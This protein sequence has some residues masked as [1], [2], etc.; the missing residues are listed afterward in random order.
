LPYLLFDVETELTP[1]PLDLHRHVPGMTVAAT[2]T[3]DG[4]LRLW[5]EQAGEGKAT[6][7]TL[8]RETAQRLVRYLHDQAAEG[9]TIVTW[10]GA[11]FDFR[12]LARASGMAQACIELAWQ[13]VDMMFWFHCVQG[14][15]VGLSRAAA[16]VG[17]SKTVGMSGAD[18]PRLWAEGQYERVKE[19][20]SQDVRAA[21][22]VYEATV[23]N[24]GLQWVNTRGQ[25]SRAS[26]PL[27]PV[28][29]AFQLPLPDTSWMRRAP[30]PRTKFVGWMLA[31]QEGNSG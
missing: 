25:L 13:H 1:G 22:A 9:Y 7:E 18:A 16:A 12:V 8:A 26:G 20:V 3:S 14:F 30:W 29:E 17:S 28:R 2:L 11:G 27:L 15:S 5:Y 4:D 19:Y 6:G 23:H 21:A 31:Y 10:N 24:L